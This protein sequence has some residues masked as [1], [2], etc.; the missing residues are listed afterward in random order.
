MMSRLQGTLGENLRPRRLL[1]KLSDLGR[2]SR[3]K[4]R[5]EERTAVP[6]FRLLELSS[7]VVEVIIRCSRPMDVL[8]MRRTCTALNVASRQ[9]QS[10]IVI[11]QSVA[12][13]HKMPLSLSTIAM[14]TVQD[15]ERFA[16]SPARSLRALIAASK[17]RGRSKKIPKL[18]SRQASIFP[19][20]LPGYSYDMDLDISL[21]LGGGYLLVTKTLTGD[22]ALWRLDVDGPVE[23]AALPFSARAGPGML[24]PLSYCIVNAYQFWGDGTVLRIVTHATPEQSTEC[25]RISV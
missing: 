22:I 17:S 15:L 7:D 16:T 21:L 10:W 12:A 13:A 18:R 9:R 23:I 8:S 20:I 2:R 24:K 5:G 19:P 1:R 14:M 4:V 11:A 3:S 6:V 25:W